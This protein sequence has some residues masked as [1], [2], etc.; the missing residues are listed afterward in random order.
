MKARNNCKTLL[1]LLSSRVH[2][3]AHSNRKFYHANV[4]GYMSKVIDC[5]LA[6]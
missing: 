5:T 3:G 4:C 6:T 2:F 1:A